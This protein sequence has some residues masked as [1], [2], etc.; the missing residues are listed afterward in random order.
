MFD[1][2]QSFVW[3]VHN[4]M[5][6]PFYPQF[7]QDCD[8]KVKVQQTIRTNTRQKAI[9]RFKNDNNNFGKKRHRYA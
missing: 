4:A 9:K 6:S 3:I 8:E 7:R 5:V 1:K 2:L